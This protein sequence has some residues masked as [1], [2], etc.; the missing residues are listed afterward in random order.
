MR[1]TDQMRKLHAQQGFTLIEVM[2]VVAVIGVLS[3]IV[4][5]AARD[6]A[7]RAKMSE[8]M[9][10]FGTCRQAISEVYQ[11]GETSPGANNWNCEDSTQSQ[12]VLAVNTTEE[13][14]IKIAVTGFGD[15]RIDTHDVTLAPL[16]FQGNR[17]IVGE[18]R[19]SSWR[20][21]SPVDGTSL[22][23]RYLPGNCRGG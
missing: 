7:I 6:Y 18:S 15:L 12:F 8:V 22:P 5:P 17:P 3:A 23:A 10:A 20:C 2:I 9:L 14:T 16:D 1:T 13:G 11:A 4:I 21:G 19:I